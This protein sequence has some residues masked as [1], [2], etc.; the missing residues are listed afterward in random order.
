MINIVKEDNIENKFVDKIYHNMF[1]KNINKKIIECKLNKNIFNPTKNSPI[2]NW[3]NR[4]IKRINDLD[5]LDLLKLD[6]FKLDTL[7]SI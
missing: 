2:N 6:S 4:L 7:N 3:Q 1:D 5:N